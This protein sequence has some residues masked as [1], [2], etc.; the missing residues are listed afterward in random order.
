MFNALQKSAYMQSAATVSGTDTGLQASY[1]SMTLKSGD[2][3]RF[4]PPLPE[5]GGSGVGPRTPQDHH[6]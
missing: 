3:C 6:H 5:S 1:S 2:P 4:G